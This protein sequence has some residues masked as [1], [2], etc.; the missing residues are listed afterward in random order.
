M[1]VGFSIDPA[2]GLSREDEL[3]CVRWA[4]ELGYRSAWTPAGGDFAAFDRCLDWHQASG[5]PTGIAVVPASGQP[6][7][8]YAQHAS[9]TWSGTG[10][11]FVL[12]VG[13][14]RMA[15]A[16]MEMGP[17]VEKLR[18]LLPRELP[19]YLAA[20]GPRM[21][22]LA[23]E[24]ADGVSLNWCSVDQVLRSRSE[25]ERAASGA[26][27]PNPP[28]AEYVRTAVDPDPAA[29][30]RALGQAI[31]GYALGPVAYRKHFARMG[32]AAELADQDSPRLTPSAGLLSGVGAWGAPG[33]VRHQFL[34]LAQGL[35]CAIVRVL[36]SQPGD[37]ESARRVLEEC[38][39]I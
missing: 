25:V 35:D 14:G 29:A 17:Y 19:I 27:R 23:G 1:E 8:F 22:R 37:A 15:H 34:Q 20:L 21:L 26:G 10:G 18:R 32:F 7:E 13:S 38:R 16:P 39:P 4:A 2:Q 5:L 36:V 33:S 12:G 30:A 11:Q 3:D 6:P 9:R 31:M 24:I 28:I